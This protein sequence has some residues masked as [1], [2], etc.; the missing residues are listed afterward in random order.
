MGKYLIDCNNL[1]IFGY[2]IS[3][4]DGNYFYKYDYLLYV[5]VIE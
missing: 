4:W 5:N 3:L 2:N 1:S